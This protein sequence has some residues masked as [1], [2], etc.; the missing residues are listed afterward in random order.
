MP[1]TVRIGGRKALLVGLGS[2]GAMVCNQILEKIAWAHESPERVPWV[3]TVIL[4]TAPLRPELILSKY[5][6]CIHLKI[7]SGDYANLI[8]N[9]QNYKE[10]IDFPSWNIPEVTGTKNAIE[11]GADNIRI[12]GR[13]A[14]LFN[15]PRVDSVVRSEINALKALTS[16]TASERFSEGSDEQYEVQFQSDRQGE[17]QSQSK[18]ADVYVY[19]VGTLCGGTASG[20]FIDV[21][22]FL[23]K[24]ANVESFPIKTTGIFLLPSQQEHNDAYR[25]NVY[26]SLVEL[27][28]FSD[29]SVRYTAQFPDS[30]KRPY[31]SMLGETPFEH[32]YLVQSRGAER[33]EYAKLVT[34]TAD[35]IYTDLIGSSGAHRDAKRTNIT[36]HFVQR[37]S[38]GATQKFFTF[39][40]AAVEFPFAKVYKGCTLLLAKR[41]FQLLAGGGDLTENQ[42]QLRLSRIPITDKAAAVRLLTTR[43]ESPLADKVHRALDAMHSQCVSAPETA[44]VTRDQIDAAFDGGAGTPLPDLPS[45]VVPL[46]IEEKQLDLIS[47]SLQCI[48]AEVRRFFTDGQCFGTKPLISFL[49]ALEKALESA[50]KDLDETPLSSIV[51]ELKQQADEVYEALCDCHRDVWLKLVFQGM[52]AKELFAE[53]LVQVLGDYYEQRLRQRCSGALKRVYDE[54]LRRVKDIRRRLED[55]R[56]GMV[57]EINAIVQGLDSLYRRTDVQSG[58]SSDPWARNINGTEIFEAGRTIEEEFKECLEHLQRQTGYVGSF[59]EFVHNEAIKSIQPYITESLEEFLAPFRGGYFDNPRESQDISEDRLLTLAQPARGSFAR[60]KNTNIIRRILARPDRSSILEGVS[61]NSSLFL[62]CRVDSPRHTDADNKSYG[63]VF[64]N[65]SDEKS[66][67]FEK[68]LRDRNILDSKVEPLDVKEPHQVLVLRERGAFSLG[69]VQMLVDE[70]P[71]PWRD[72][73]ENALISCHSR[74]DVAEW[75]TWSRQNH[76]DRNKAKIVFLVG[77]ALGIIEFRSHD[78][79]RLEYPPKSPSD[80]GT[81]RFGRDL[82][83]VVSVMRRHGVQGYIEQKISNFWQLNGPADVTDRIIAFIKESDGKFVEGDERLGK[84]RI[85]DYLLEYIRGDNDLLSAY[86]AV[87]PDF[88]QQ[89]LLRDDEEG[90]KAY[91]CPN[92]KQKLGYTSDCLYVTEMEQGKAKRSRKCAFCGYHL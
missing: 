69:T 52:R 56:S 74:G 39:G 35:Y 51:S 80:P 59:D 40:L 65:A 17:V 10:K 11:N 89:S 60:L 20:C 44:S 71:S 68:E 1:E 85:E 12:M 55:H 14:F 84:Q 45:R 36:Q 92:C 22:Y 13:L 81:V 49:D 15:Y 77:A 23:R 61:E 37:D 54:A 8:A 30:P 46:T 27:N 63:F 64:Y 19:V 29:D 72:A 47:S 75:T 87:Y 57:S 34:S 86:Q 79:Y 24:L 82:N 5:A 42:I 90:R 32:T 25:R 7:D 48:D 31:V 33:S 43:D 28:H 6:K 21:G 73:Y 83:E 4:E 50:R 67:E 18:D 70:D 3:R 2:T 91:F 26:A 88:S 78:D 9:P 53:R 62:G 41:G 66:G 58:S 76:E 16:Q 38:W